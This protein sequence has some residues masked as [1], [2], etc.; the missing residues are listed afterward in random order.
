MGRPAPGSLKI[1]D[2]ALRFADVKE[3]RPE[4][5]L[6]AR[7][8][9]WV[10]FEVQHAVNETK[11]RRWPLVVSVLLD[12]HRAM[13]ELIVLTHRRRVARWAAEDIVWQGPR[14]T[15]LALKP[16]VLLIDLDAAGRL[17]NEGDATLALGAA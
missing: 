14:G 16:Q 9:P 3:G 12:K 1:R 8:L 5:V 15:R 6:R 17:L 13:G 7:G 11:R 2:S 4:L 10:G